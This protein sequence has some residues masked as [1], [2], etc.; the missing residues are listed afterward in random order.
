LKQI[1]L[2]FDNVE[3]NGLLDAGSQFNQ[4][5]GS[6]MS[7]DCGLSV[8]IPPRY[9]DFTGFHAK[10]RHKVNGLRYTQDDHFTAINKMQNSKVEEY[11]SCRKA[12]TFLK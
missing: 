10:Y 1:L 9:C 11:L 5:L 4:Q 7:I 2:H 3:N 12:N 6:Y 8:K